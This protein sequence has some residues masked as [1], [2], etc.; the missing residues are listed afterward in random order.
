MVNFDFT[1]NLS[2]I[3]VLLLIVYIWVILKC[4]MFWAQ[5]QELLRWG[6]LHRDK[7]SCKLSK[8]HKLESLC[9][10][11]KWG[12]SGQRWDLILR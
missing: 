2:I 12:L 8:G 11:N 6:K 7:Y 3:E 10:Q 9:V 5:F 4:T 1:Q